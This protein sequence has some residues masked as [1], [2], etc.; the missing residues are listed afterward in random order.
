MTQRT[1]SKKETKKAAS[2]KKKESSAIEQIGSESVRVSVKVLEK[3]MSLGSELVLARNQLNLIVE[4]CDDSQ[5]VQAIQQV[6]SVTSQLQETIM[7]T[8]M[9]S[10]G[11]VLNKFTRVVR[12]LSNTLGKKVKLTIEGQDVELDKTIIEAIGDPLMHIVRNSMDHGLETPDVRLAAGKREVGNLFIRAYQEAGKV[13]IEISD[14]GGGID[15]E[16]VLGKA[17]ESGILSEAEASSLSEREIVNLIFKPGF[18]TADEVTEVS[19]RGVGMDVVQTNLSAQGGTVD[20]TSKLGEG[21]LIK[22]SL[23]LTLAVMPA[24]LVS[25]DSFVYAIP[26]VSLLQVVRVAYTAID[27]RIQIIAGAMVIRFMDE[28]LPIIPGSRFLSGE[29]DPFDVNAEKYGFTEAVNIAVVASGDLKY[30]MILDYPLDSQEIVVKPLG[31]HLNMLPV[32]SGATILGSGEVAPILNIT[33]IAHKCGIDHIE[34]NGVSVEEGEGESTAELQHL[35]LMSNFGNEQLAMP[36]QMVKRIEKIAAGDVEDVG[37]IRTCK[38]RGKSLSLFK[39]EDVADLCRTQEA[40]YYTVAVFEI[41]GKEH[42]ILV[43]EIVECLEVEAHFDEFPYKQTGVHGSAR[44][45]DKLVLLLDHYGIVAKIMPQWVSE[46]SAQTKTAV[47]S[48]SEKNILVVDDSK[49]FVNQIAGFLEEDGYRS[50]KAENGKEALDLLLGDECI[51]LVL[52]DIEMPVMDGWEFTRQVRQM[53]QFNDL[54]II[55]VT[56]VAGEMAEKKGK[57]LGIN[58]YLIKLDREEILKTVKKY[59]RKQVG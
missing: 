4:S 20:L 18:S 36:M 38:Y 47:D 41:A 35:L 58:D 24:L 23:P 26:Q 10:I 28:L 53:S 21:T 11:I 34:D 3:M 48:N 46:T 2:A 1:V 7:Q 31:R 33:G 13:L 43:N 8:R 6:D 17:L 12:D 25:I 40:D 30:G 29:A 27:Q 9:Q 54:P 45:A 19:G 52:L 42:G 39:I 22:I 5:T 15:P 50:V 14:D 37:S 49:F 55:A 56:S 44:I 59:L 32:Y 57:E 16:R 51:D